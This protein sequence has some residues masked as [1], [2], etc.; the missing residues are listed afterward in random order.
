VGDTVLS[1]S[2]NVVNPDLADMI[3]DRALASNTGWMAEA[4]SPSDLNVQ[5]RAFVQWFD[6]P[7]AHIP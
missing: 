3:I 1:G 6:N 2:Y 5:I 4:S 7:P